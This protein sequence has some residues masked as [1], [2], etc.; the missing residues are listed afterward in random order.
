MIEIAGGILLAVLVLFFLPL[1]FQ[2]VSLLLVA[3]IVVIPLLVL[4][5]T[6]GK[7]AIGVVVLVAIGFGLIAYL[8]PRATAWLNGRAEAKRQ[9]RLYGQPIAYSQDHLD[10]A[11]RRGRYTDPE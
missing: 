9:R 4:W 1:F 10:W 8:K 6:L 7:D 3:A 2:A 5:A 11:N